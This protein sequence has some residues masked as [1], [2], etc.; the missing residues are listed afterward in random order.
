MWAHYNMLVLILKS[1]T[2]ASLEPIE[3][4]FT[5]PSYRATFSNCNLRENTEGTM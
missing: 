2:E 3:K 5:L 1:Y 4:H